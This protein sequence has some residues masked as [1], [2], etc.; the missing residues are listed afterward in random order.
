M[1]TYVVLRRSAWESEQDLEEANAIAARI[2]EEE[3]SGQVR[4]IRSYAIEEEDGTLGIVSIY[5]AED[6][7]VIMEHAQRS[8]L[9][10]DEVLPMTG[11]EISRDDP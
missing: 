8:E 7:D 11:M 2:E 3:M 9:P 1:Q 10:V 6:E 5:Q 4:S